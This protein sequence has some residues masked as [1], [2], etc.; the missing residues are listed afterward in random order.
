MPIYELSCKKCHHQFDV[1]SKT[2]SFDSS[3]IE[4]ENCGKKGCEKQFTTPMIQICPDRPDRYER[5]ESSHREKV[6]DPERA[7]RMRKK[8]FGTEGIS[9]TKSPYYHKEKRVKAQG[10]SQEVDKKS[11]IQNAARNPNAMKAA[12]NVLN[13]KK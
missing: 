13:K 5:A 9:I 6:K 7:R 4:C 3:T 2:F 12:I 11:F 10:T 8:K 1:Y